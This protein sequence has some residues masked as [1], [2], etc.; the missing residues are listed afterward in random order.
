[1][2]VHHLS[3][4]Y[5]LRFRRLRER[6]RHGLATTGRA[7]GAATGRRVCDGDWRLA[8]RT[9]SALLRGRG[10]RCR[11]SR[12]EAREVLLAVGGDDEPGA[13]DT[14]ALPLAGLRVADVA[15]EGPAIQREL[16]RPVLAGQRAD[17]VRVDPGEH[18]FAVGQR[19]GPDPRALADA[20]A[21]R[22]IVRVLVEAVEDEA[23]TVGDHPPHLG[24]ALVDQLLGEFDV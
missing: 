12:G 21:G 10:H 1:M 5:H 24:D 22:R 18:G 16:L 4:R 13:A 3:C 23:R 20:V 11:R 6:G 9:T 19:W 14:L 2:L 15:V 7:S 17:L 8:G